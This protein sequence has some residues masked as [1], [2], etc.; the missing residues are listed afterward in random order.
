LR[1]CIN[2]KTEHA[3][4]TYFATTM[5]FIAW[6]KVLF[7]HHMLLYAMTAFVRVIPPGFLMIRISSAEPGTAVTQHPQKCNKAVPKQKS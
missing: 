3:N 7:L 4:P 1:V 5:V 6:A 2:T